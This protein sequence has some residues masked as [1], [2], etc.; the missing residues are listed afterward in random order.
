MPQAMSFQI[1]C[2]ECGRSRPIV[3]ANAGES[4][5][6]LCGKQL[7]VPK[8]SELRRIAGQ[9]TDFI[10]I[11][12]QL[13]TM[14]LDKQLPPDTQC[15]F[16]QVKTATTLDCWVECE[17]ARV[18]SSGGWDT[19]F[20]ILLFVIWPVM[21]LIYYAARVNRDAPPS[22]NDQVVRTPLPICENCLQRTSRTEASI[23]TFLRS[24]ALYR[25]LLDAYP[26]SRV[27]AS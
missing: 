7:K 10:A 8:L 13:R 20:G 19:M 25:Q 11:A 23:R 6:C 16:C 27:G 9:P 5:P 17:R 1:T 24:V 18:R 15:M 4:I 3:T 21:G 22:G 2:D 26:A 14:Y 12:D